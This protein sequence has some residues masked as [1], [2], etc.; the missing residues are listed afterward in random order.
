MGADVDSQLQAFEMHHSVTCVSVKHVVVGHLSCGSI[1][2]GG[3]G[4]DGWS[5]A[6]LGCSNR[7]ISYLH[8]TRATSPVFPDTIPPSPA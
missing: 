3:R 4:T 8:L 2:D 1:S 6:S 7:G 5:E